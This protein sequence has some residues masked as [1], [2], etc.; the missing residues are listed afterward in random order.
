MKEALR[1]TP[2]LPDFSVRELLL[3]ASTVGAL[4]LFLLVRLEAVAM[5]VI[6]GVALGFLSIVL[7]FQFPR[8]LILAYLFLTPLIL[9][10]V[11]GITPLEA[12]FL[13]YSILCIL[14]F[15]VIPAMRL[16]LPLETTLDKTFLFLLFYF[17]PDPF[18][19]Y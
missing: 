16:S 15:T 17:P 1:Y 18:L 10:P 11:E 5:F 9:E 8:L 19:V 6:P 12:L 13:G 7:L 2:Q 4:F 3:F 14:V